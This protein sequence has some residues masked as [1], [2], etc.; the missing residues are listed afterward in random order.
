MMLLDAVIDRDA[1][2]EVFTRVAKA[3]TKSASEQVFQ[4]VQ[5]E[6][7]DS[8]Q[9]RFSASDG[10][11]T[12]VSDTPAVVFGFGNAL[13][14]P[15]VAKLVKAIPSGE[16]VRIT[17][18]ATNLFI[19]AYSSCLN[20][21]WRLN[22]E[23]GSIAYPNGQIVNTYKV[24][25]WFNHAVGKVLPSI[26]GDRVSQQLK[27]VQVQESRI[28]AYG[29][30]TYR[31]ETAPFFEHPIDMLIPYAIARNLAGVD[32][33]TELEEHLAFSRSGDVVYVRKNGQMYPDLDQ[34][35]LEPKDPNSVNLDVSNEELSV[36]IAAIK[37][38]SD[39]SY[40]EL[41]I[42]PGRVRLTA[43][44]KFNQTAEACVDLANYNDAPRVVGCDLYQFSKFVEDPDTLIS[45]EPNKPDRMG[46]I[47]FTT[48]DGTSFGNMEQMR[49]DLLRRTR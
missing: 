30:Q 12:R 23:E 1:L 8:T 3:T 26:V 37:P 15:V 17:A 6:A 24:G 10:V 40:M 29:G 14:P 2:L 20:Q 4:N 43:V 49:A 38:I 16:D 41:D 18:D 32:T 34:F 19:V 36:A 47:Y 31:C 7:N 27:Y 5:I 35:V 44:D 13:L 45:I 9:V 11:I 42:R 25:S 48:S 22:L 21:S 39:D 46:L 33:L 28:R